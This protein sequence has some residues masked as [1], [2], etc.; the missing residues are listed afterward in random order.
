MAALATDVKLA[1]HPHPTL[2]ETIMEAIDAQGRVVDVTAR[3]AET[4]GGR[5]ALQD[6]ARG[7]VVQLEPLQLGDRRA[8]LTR[9]G[10]A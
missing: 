5:A 3:I 8:S 1:I 7:E 6:D 9:H 4:Q 2:S 10:G